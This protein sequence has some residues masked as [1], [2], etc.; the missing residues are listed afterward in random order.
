MTPLGGS[1][2]FGPSG[3]GHGGALADR[4]RVPAADH[5][6]VP[7]PGGVDLSVLAT[8]SDK[9]LDGYRA[10]GPPLH[11]EPGAEVL[12]VAASPGSLPLYATAA[13]VALGAPVRYVDRD[14]QRVAAAAQ[15]GA[16]THVHR[17]PWPKR[18]DPAPITVDVTGD[19][20][21]L[22]CTL[23]S[24]E[25]YGRCTA[26]AIAFEPTTPLPMLEMYTR[27]I[28]LHTSRADSRRFLPQVLALVGS[29]RLGS[30]S[31]WPRR[32]LTPGRR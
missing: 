24:T 27:G 2:G 4:L 7:A 5:L 20:G 18:Y 9:V 23:R 12:V 28:T 10:V 16:D 8:L 25:R 17:G 3:G 19:G 22:A 26:L 13:A 6:L 1:F 32:L 15:L 14:P 30:G 31:V 21:G 11:A 29:G